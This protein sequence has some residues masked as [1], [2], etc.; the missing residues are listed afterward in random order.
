[1]VKIGQNSRKANS[2]N[3]STYKYQLA[4]REQHHQLKLIY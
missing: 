1:M 3:Q 2:Y 4:I